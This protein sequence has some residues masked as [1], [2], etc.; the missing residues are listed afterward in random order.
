[1][2]VAYTSAGSVVN[3]AYGWVFG[4]RMLWVRVMPPSMTRRHF[5]RTT[6]LLAASA[7][8]PRLAWASDPF[9]KL[10]ATAQA[11][12]VRTGQVTPI[13]LVDA[14]IKRIEALNPKLNAFVTTCFDRA[15]EQAKGKLPDGP[16]RG[17]PY[18]IK[19]LSNLEGTR[20]T[21]GSRL[22]EHNISKGNDGIVESAL[23]AGLVPLGKTNTPEFGLLA[24]TESLLLGPAHNPWNLAHS[25]GGSSGGAAAAVAS[26]MLPFAQASDGGGS[27]RNPASCCG[28]FGLK[29]S[30]GRMYETRQGPP[31]DIAV[32]FAVSRTVRDS[33]RLFAASE[34]TGPYASLLP[35]GEVLSPSPRR[36][37]IAFTTSSAM[38]DR[39]HPDVEAATEKTAKLCEDLGHTIIP[40]DHPVD[41][42]EFLDNF[43]TLWAAGPSQLESYAWIIG[44]RQFRLVSADDVLEPWTTGLADW[45]RKKDDGAVARA[46]Q[47]CRQ[48]TMDYAAFFEKY[49]VQLIPVLKDPPIKL[50]E[51]GP[52]VPFDTLL[53]RVVA[54]SSFTP[55]YNA[56]GAP[57]MSVP[58]FT[59]SDGLPI[60]SQ[61]GA[62]VGD[63]R[64]LFELAYELEQAQP[65]ENRWPPHAAV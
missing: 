61:F 46:V 45:L 59:S 57:A 26:G 54:Y 15:R 4:L 52:D 48:V 37:K 27:I 34:H 38:G 13:E 49:D 50:G 22:F 11:E 10:D 21:M 64:T 53:E 14:A 33:A 63:E 30:R 6:G 42:D 17:V 56:A 23:E 8:S 29:P 19:D 44:L 7:F 20:C 28:V 24:T 25:T 65:W 40:A 5:L 1:M 16:F 31:G 32:N 41:A 9:V 60:G 12:L 35:V 3:V 43:L 58:L 39:P 51:Q 47:Y 62:R 55:P 36:L 18:A 2:P